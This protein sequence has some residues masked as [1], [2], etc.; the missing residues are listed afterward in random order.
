MNIRTFLIVE[1]FLC[2]FFIILI[3]SIYNKHYC[4]PIFGR[5]NSIQLSS[6]IK[7]YPL[8]DVGDKFLNLKCNIILFAF[9]AIVS[10]ILRNL[11][12]SFFLLL[13]LSFVF[14]ADIYFSFYLYKNRMQILKREESENQIDYAFVYPVLRSNKYVLVF[15]VIIFVLLF[16][17]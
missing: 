12:S 9:M 13:I 3:T 1:I 16:F 10:R 14:V 4:N 15:K 2:I 17:F 11:F 8:F 5:I 7:F 6:F